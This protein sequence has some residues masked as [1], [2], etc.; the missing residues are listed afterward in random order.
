MLRDGLR[1]AL[2]KPTAQGAV[3]A[4]RDI[5]GDFVPGDASLIDM[6][7]PGSP[8]ILSSGMLR[9]L[10]DEPDARGAVKIGGDNRNA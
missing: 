2:A 10:G 4:L 3:S 7:Q 6:T 5:L 9:D 8:A 1:A